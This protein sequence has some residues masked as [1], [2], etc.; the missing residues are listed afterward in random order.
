MERGNRNNLGILAEEEDEE[1][2][3]RS[4]DGRS[5]EDSESDRDDDADEGVRRGE[6]NKF[7]GLCD[8]VLS[9]MAI[10]HDALQDLLEMKDEML[11]HSLPPTVL[12]QLAMV[13]GRVFRSISDLGMPVNELVRMVRV[14]STPWEEKS[15][16]LKKLHEDYESK[17]RQLNIAIKRLQLVDA[18]SKR[19]AREKRIMNWEKLFS[20]MTSAKG[21]GRRWKFL[22]ET[23][24]QKAKLGLEHVQAYTQGLEDDSESEEEVEVAQVEEAP[25]AGEEDNSDPQESEGVQET[26]GSKAEEGETNE[27]D[28]E[29]DIDDE[30]RGEEG[31]ESRASGETGDTASDDAPIV[32]VHIG[33]GDT[34]DNNDA[35]SRSGSPKKVRFE[36]SFARPL[37]IR[38]P[39]KDVTC[40]TEEPDYDRS[41]FIRIFCPEGM[42]QTELKCSL[43]YS[44]NMFK[45]PI[46][47]APPDESPEPTDVQSVAEEKSSKRPQAARKGVERSLPDATQ[48]EPELT[49]HKKKKFHEFEIK[50]PDEVKEGILLLGEKP[51]PEPDNI[52]IA[53][54]QGQ[55]EEII[56]MATIDFQDIKALSLET[57]NLPPPHGDDDIAGVKSRANSLSIASSLDEGERDD[58]ESLSDSVDIPIMMDDSGPDN[59]LACST[60]RVG[61]A[62]DGDLVKTSEPLPFPIYSLQ[63]GGKSDAVH[64]PCGTVPLLM[65][66]GKRARPLR[67]N[68]QCGTLGVYD[69]V[70]E[71]TGFDMSTTTKEDLHKD[72]QDEALS[73]VAFTPDPGQETVPKSDYDQLIE[74]H[75]EEMVILQE[76]Y[77]KRLQ[78]LMNN[79]QNMQSENAMLS[80]TARPGSRQQLQ[81]SSSVASRVSSTQG[82]VTP[83]TSKRSERSDPTLPTG[84]GGDFHSRAGL[85][86]QGSGAGV[87]SSQ[88]SLRPI[89]RGR[90]MPD[91]VDNMGGVA[92]ETTFL[93]QGG[94]SNAR[95]RP[96]P[97]KPQKPFK[98]FRIG[99]PLPR[100]GEHLPQDFFERLQLYE[101]ETRQHKQDLSERTLNDIK[102]N[103]EK[104]LAGQHK[105]SHREEQLWDALKDVSLPALFMPFKSGNIFNPRAH[106]YFHPTG[107]TEVRLTQPPSVFQLPPLPNSKVGVVNL[108]ELSKNFHSRGPAWLVERYIQQ[109]QPLPAEVQGYHGY[110]AYPQTPAPT[111]AQPQAVVGTSGNTTESIAENN[112]DMDFPYSPSTPQREREVE[113]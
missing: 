53:V 85:T 68:R 83:V 88:Q 82:A 95:P 38:P 33:P 2:I 26:E 50:L 58:V 66:W 106:Q 19:V 37:T 105:L 98:N 49:S 10:V 35:A 46:L 104:K 100:W 47:D 25:A 107:A 77:E 65:Y 36:E 101:E 42:E 1:N 111:S 110:Q 69:L 39:T 21:H 67:Y 7:D 12:I 15:A 103:L 96:Q 11:K 28:E 27:E 30:G 48:S 56:A 55:F 60:P 34:G 13:S 64:M 3:G 99:R 112:N 74:R 20:K 59:L 72:M 97:P 113:S 61:G 45:T 16:A 81:R 73:A 71:M 87:P 93:S 102:E 89:S 29:D 78:E 109:Q 6:P 63:A 9:A 41:L 57:V 32:T 23:I 31:S 51:A 14:Y 17:Q 75:Q 24:K 80:Q 108:F 84:S 90:T 92:G 5:E 52:Q 54:H 8:G 44:G 22:I 4:D 18:H 76:E 86:T 94:F 70:Y 40:S 91:M 79:L 62:Q 43:A